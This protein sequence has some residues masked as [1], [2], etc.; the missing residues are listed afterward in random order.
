MTPLIPRRI[1]TGRLVSRGRMC[2]DSTTN[3]R[4]EDRNRGVLGAH[5]GG[6]R[7][8]SYASGYVGV[9]RSLVACFVRDE[10]VAGS[11]PVT[12]TTKRLVSDGLAIWRRS[13]WGPTHC[14]VGLSVA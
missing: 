9:W 11:N 5:F 14:A 13:R 12:P 2:T 7:L 6:N 10:E 4:W 8:L 1:E 3:H